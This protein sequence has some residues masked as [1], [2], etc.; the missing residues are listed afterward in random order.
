MNY[1]ITE[2][3][4]YGIPVEIAYEIGDWGY[5]RTLKGQEGFLHMD[6]L[7]DDLSGPIIPEPEPIPG[8]RYLRKS[9]FWMQVMEIRIMVRVL[10]GFMRKMLFWQRL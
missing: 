1:P 2:K 8:I 3:L 6:F 4:T 10:M 7:S 9:S 5:V